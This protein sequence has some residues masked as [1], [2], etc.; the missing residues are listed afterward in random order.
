MSTLK[1]RVGDGRREPILVRVEKRKQHPD[2]PLEFVEQFRGEVLVLPAPK[3]RVL[4]V[5]LRMGP[6]AFGY[7]L[8][9]EP[10]RP[11]MRSLYECFID[12]EQE[13]LTL[14]PYPPFPDAMIAVEYDDAG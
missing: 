7:T 1:I 12:A 9:N 3:G 10:F 2:A 6:R 4:S 5:A 13:S 14:C 11:D 8:V